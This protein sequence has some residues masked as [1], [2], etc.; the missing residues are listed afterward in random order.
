MFIRMGVE[1]LLRKIDPDA[2]F[3]TLN[4]EDVDEWYKAKD[5]T[6]DKVVWCGMPLFWS[7]PTHHTREIFWWDGLLAP[8]MTHRK[9]DLLIIGAGTS[10][11]VS[12]NHRIAFTRPDE[13]L[14]TMTDLMI[15]SFDMT[16]RDDCIKFL[17]PS[18]PSITTLPCP[19]YFAQPEKPVI[20]HPITC[21]FML[22]GG[23]YPELEPHLSKA[24]PQSLPIIARTFFQLNA[25]FCPHTM[26]ESELAST[27][28]WSQAQIAPP[29]DTLHHLKGSG[30]HLGNRIHAAIIAASAGAKSVCLGYDLRLRAAQLCG[31]EVIHAGQYPYPFPA[32]QR[33][34]TE[35]T[36][37]SYLSI[38]S[39]FTG[40]AMPQPS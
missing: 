19:A 18:S 13:I 29:F 12:D 32:V 7:F 39:R 26:A 37:R 27:L 1:H 9:S 22:K 28:G 24:W 11:V 15:G 36:L 8:L 30:Y 2:V 33:P 31:C 5:S 14:R 21:N 16:L 20:H 6:H 17:L 23:H 34:N 3:T 4:K 35:E 10:G 25:F 38:L 40:L